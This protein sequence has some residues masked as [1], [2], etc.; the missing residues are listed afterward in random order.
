MSDLDKLINAVS[1]LLFKTGQ[2]PTKEKL[3]AIVKAQATVLALV[4]GGSPYSEEEVQCA[5]AKIQTR[6]DTHMGLGV[7]FEGEDYKPWLANCRGNIDFYYWSRYH[8]QLKEKFSV[9][10]VGKLDTITDKILDHLED[11]KKEGSWE[12]KGLVVGHVQSGKTANYIGLISKAADAGYK[13][14]IVLGGMLN[15]LRNQTQARIDSDFFGYCTKNKGE[16]GV[17]K[18]GNA[19]RPLSLTSSIAD[20]SKAT[21]DKVQFDLNALKEPVVFVLKKNVTTLRNVKN[22]LESGNKR[23]LSGFPLLLIDDEADHASINTNKEDRDPTK[24]NLG[25]RELLNLFPR[26]SYVGYTATPFANIFIDPDNE[27]Q[28]QNGDLYKDLFPR[29]FILS[30]DPP[31][32]YVGAEAIFGEESDSENLRDIDDNEDF[33][34]IRHKKEWVLPALPPSLE[35]AIDCF[36]LTKTIREL[37]GQTGKHHSMMVNVSRFTDVQEQLKGAVSEFLKTRQHAIKL[38][39]GLTEIEALSSSSMLREIKSV[40][41]TEYSNAGFKWIEVQR[42]LN[43]AASSITVVSINNRSTDRLDY[44]EYPNGRSLIAIGGLGLSRGL[45]LEGLSISYF[46]RNSIMYDTLLQMGRWFGYREDY[47][48]LCRIFMKQEAVSWYAHISSAV[49]ELREKFREME[50]RG[51]T[52]LEFGLR[53]RSHPAALIVTAKNKMR[54][55]SQVVCEIALGGTFA[56]TFRIANNDQKF[57]YNKEVF[58]DAIMAADKVKSA[59]PTKLG[60]LWR[61]VPIQ[62]LENIAKRFQNT[63]KSPYTEPEPLGKYIEL[64]REEDGVKFCDILLRSVDSGDKDYDCAGKAISPIRRR[65]ADSTMD[66]S[67]LTFKKWNI[68][69]PDDESAGIPDEVVR[70]IKNLNKGNPNRKAYRKYRADNGMPPLL[71]LFFAKV[72]VSKHGAP[73]IVPAYGISFP[74]DSEDRSRPERKVAYTANTTWMLSNTEAYESDNEA[75]EDVE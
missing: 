25:I 40:W 75:E 36:I 30:L 20:F 47:Q 32:N 2:I 49:E 27:D 56:N 9:D 65:L 3:V 46:L 21:A 54:S 55:A 18:F 42:H 24:I 13:V 17:A 19:R 4:P 29:D 60:L 22:W 52:P 59:E 5:V 23:G 31:S 38:Y 34:P 71:I 11:P 74:G 69:S 64:I 7:L 72:S 8:E 50:R 70:E 39:T 1:C 61:G 44:A 66:T 37:R 10:V 48:D 63:P 26:N 51:L 16:I 41:E 57:A 33:I 62:I 67:C 28:M 15:S 45:T 14:I 58:E 53:V 43:A 68:S 35:K 73:K 12:R 6:H